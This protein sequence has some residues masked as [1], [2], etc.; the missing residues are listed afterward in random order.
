MAVCWFQKFC[1]GYL[2]L[3][4]KPQRFE[5]KLNEEKSK[6]MVKVDLISIYYLSLVIHL[7]CI[8]YSNIRIFYCNKQIKEKI[9][10]I[11]KDMD[12]SFFITLNKL[13]ELIKVLPHSSYRLDISPQDFFFHLEL[14]IISK[15]QSLQKTRCFK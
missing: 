2:D 1:S 8:T 7:G 13:T 3:K 6:A 10:I 15:Q 5:T 12:P 14:R 11:H 4:N 9:T